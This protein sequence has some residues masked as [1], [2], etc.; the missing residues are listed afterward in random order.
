MKFWNIDQWRNWKRS[1]I[2]IV[3]GN[4]QVAWRTSEELCRSMGGFLELVSGWR[5]SGNFG[6]D[7]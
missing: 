6:G 4:K 1:Y 3:G 5:S 7:Q 2:Y